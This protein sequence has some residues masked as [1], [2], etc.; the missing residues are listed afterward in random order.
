MDTE[1]SLVAWLNCNGLSKKCRSLMDLT[2]L[3]LI[4]ELLAQM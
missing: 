1:K 2:D 4:Y 3:R